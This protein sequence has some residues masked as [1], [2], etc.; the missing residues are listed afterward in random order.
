MNQNYFL[1]SI[2]NIESN[3]N[4]RE[5]QIEAYKA[6][7]DHLTVQN[8]PEH[9]IVVLPTG[10]GKTG[11]MGLIP[12]GNSLGRVLII[13]PQLVIKDAVLDSLDPEHPKN[14]WMARNIFNKFNDLPSV[15]E[16]DSTTSKWALDEANIVILNIHKL[17]DRLDRALVK[18]VASD[19]FDLIIIDEA[20]HSTAPTWEKTLEYFSSAKVVKLT[21]V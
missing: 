2:P 5:P 21:E 6:V 13:T 1:E 18:R 8:N 16:Y 10:V 19:Y 12:Y 4:L 15:I 11:V 3:E 7:Y 17:Q 9:A 20:H 14:F